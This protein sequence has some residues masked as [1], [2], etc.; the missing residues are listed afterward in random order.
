MVKV[1]RYTGK[2]LRRQK[3]ILIVRQDRIGDVVLS[4]PIPRAIK[5]QWP[6]SFIAV[7]VNNYTKDVY[8]NN[9]YVDKIII[10]DDIPLTGLDNFIIK[11]ERN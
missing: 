1:I 7:L 3:R 8:I 9:P 4:T 5:N 2:A 6:D 10:Y 11:D